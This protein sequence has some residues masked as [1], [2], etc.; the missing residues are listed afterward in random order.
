MNEMKCCNL[1]LTGGTARAHSLF[2]MNKTHT[3]ASQDTFCILDNLTIKL[4]LGQN[5]NHLLLSSGLILKYPLPQ[6][7]AQLALIFLLPHPY[8]YLIPR[9][10]A[11]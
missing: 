10:L 7:R 9:P 6:Y 3:L 2:N 4:Y 8:L 1:I 11:L 5:I